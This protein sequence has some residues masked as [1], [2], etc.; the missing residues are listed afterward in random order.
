[1]EDFSNI[2]DPFRLYSDQKM[3]VYFM[4]FGTSL[5]LDKQ[6][7][8]LVIKQQLFTSYAFVK[9]KFLLSIFKLTKKLGNNSSHVN[10]RPKK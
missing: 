10:F 2:I 5:I 6:I 9:P 7:L 8:K 1:M 4:T 3:Q